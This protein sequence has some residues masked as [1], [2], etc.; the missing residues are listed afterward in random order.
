MCV[1][2]LPD[3]VEQPATNCAQMAAFWLAADADSATTTA[4]AASVAC[5]ASTAAAATT[6]TASTT[7]AAASA[8]TTD[9]AA[10]APAASSP[11]V[12]DDAKGEQ[13]GRLHHTS[14]SGLQR[15]PRHV[16]QGWHGGVLREG[17]IFHCLL[18]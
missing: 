9:A 3:G 18:T 1:I 7:S 10:A 2:Y 16:C 11:D 15:A 5:T 4:T 14:L 17:I 12:P 8:T 6:P 13:D